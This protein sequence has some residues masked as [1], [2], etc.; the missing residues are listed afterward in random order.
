[1]VLKRYATHLM[2][3]QQYSA[4]GATF[5][6]A[7]EYAAALPCWVQSGECGL[8]M[9]MAARLGQTPAEQAT[10][11]RTAAEALSMMCRFVDAARLLIDY[12]HE[13]EEGVA[14]LAQG[15]VQLISS[16]SF[17]HQY[18]RVL[19]PCSVSTYFSIDNLTVTCCAAPPFCHST[20]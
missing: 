15:G 19:Y 2:A 14:L 7:G 11:A 12:C 8:L 17:F 3:K 9:T 1:M 18:L 6:A 13:V 20:I 5:C 16:S 4:A 10:L